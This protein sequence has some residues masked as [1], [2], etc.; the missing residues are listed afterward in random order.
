VLIQNICIITESSIELSYSGG[1]ADI[2]QISIHEN[3][4]ATVVNTNQKECMVTQH[5]RGQFGKTCLNEDL[6]SEL[7][8]P[9]VRL[10]KEIELSL[11]H[12]LWE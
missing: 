4:T 12:L 5:F 2:D 1:E 10:I 11:L 3:I 7:A 9:I 8:K 6:L